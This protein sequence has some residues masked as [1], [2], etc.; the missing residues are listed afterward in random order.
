MVY[1]SNNYWDWCKYLIAP[2]KKNLKRPRPNTF[3]CANPKTR[4]SGQCFR[5]NSNKVRTEPTCPISAR[6]HRTSNNSSDNHARLGV[7]YDSFCPC[8]F[9]NGAWA[10]P[11][12]VHL[13]YC[14]RI[15]FAICG[16]LENQQSYKLI[17][18]WSHI[19][20]TNQADS[21][22]LVPFMFP[23]KLRAISREILDISEE[24]KKVLQLQQWSKGTKQSNC[25]EQRSS[26]KQKK[27]QKN[28]TGHILNSLCY[29]VLCNGLWAATTASA[30]VQ[31]RLHTQPEKGFSSPASLKNERRWIFQGGQKLHVSKR[32]ADPLHSSTLFH[33]LL[34]REKGP[35][36]KAKSTCRRVMILVKNS[37]TSWIAQTEQ[38]KWK[39]RSTTTLRW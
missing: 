31:Q 21:F 17:A 8:M 27:S 26:N 9:S 32:I 16:L 23:L 14:Q 11:Q 12:I 25:E 34:P 4:S 6:L 28:K 30:I 38:C 10:S 39:K 20:S 2:P 35:A 29:Y 18:R 36:L 1:A 5:G 24:R 13:H 15:C 7:P 33:T 22:Q 3:I 19:S 37:G